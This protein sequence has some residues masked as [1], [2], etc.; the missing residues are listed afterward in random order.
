MGT[1]HAATASKNRLLVYV[2]PRGTMQYLARL[3]SWTVASKSVM[4]K[5]PKWSRGKNVQMSL[6]CMQPVCK[7]PRTVL[8]SRLIVC[9]ENDMTTYKSLR[10][11]FEHASRAGLNFAVGCKKDG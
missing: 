9:S 2:S 5:A 8:E 11:Q 10:S 7:R 6:L 4:L 1:Q 3:Y